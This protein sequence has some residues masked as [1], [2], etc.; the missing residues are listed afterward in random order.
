LAIVNR[1]RAVKT[2][3]VGVFAE[4]PRPDAMERSGPSQGSGHDAGV[5]PK[6]LG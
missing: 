3:L 4:Q 6:H 2:N 5:L 1:E